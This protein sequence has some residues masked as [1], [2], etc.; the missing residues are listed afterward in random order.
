MKLKEA[1]ANGIKVLKEAK[2]DKAV[3]TLKSFETLSKVADGKATKIVVPSELQNI[4]TI[5]STI[6]AM[7]KDK[8][9]K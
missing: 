2:A 3:L 8:E 9:E 5:G 6:E 1:E 7:F 4:A